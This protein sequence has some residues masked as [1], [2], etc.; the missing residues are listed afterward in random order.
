MP[1]RFE[2]DARG[3]AHFMH[4][5]EV[6]GAWGSFGVGVQLR[7]AMR[8]QRQHLAGKWYCAAHRPEKDDERH[9]V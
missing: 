5:C 7:H 8:L 9:Q 1:A 4:E 2:K 6:C 3:A